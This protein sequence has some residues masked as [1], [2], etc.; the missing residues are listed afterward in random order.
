ML[1]RSLKVDVPSDQYIHA[2]CAVGGGVVLTYINPSPDAL[3][4]NI[5]FTAG[6]MPSPCTNYGSETAG[7]VVEKYILTAPQGNLTSDQVELNG[8]VL[9][10]SSALEPSN[11]FHETV[12]N[13]PPFSYG[14][15]VSK[16]SAK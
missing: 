12:V 13:V 2:A 9:S 5:T 16:A 10:M 3:E 4:V 14:F 11:S 8:K 6:D 1:F 7:M 15:L